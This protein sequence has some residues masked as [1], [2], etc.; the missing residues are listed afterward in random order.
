MGEGTGRCEYDGCNEFLWL[1]FVTKFEFNTAY[2]AHIIADKPGGPRGDATLSDK[3]KDDFLS[4]LML[5]CDKH[6]RL[7]DKERAKEHPVEKLREM[8]E[9]QEKRIELLT[10]I[11]DNKKSHVL[12][13]GANIGHHN[14]S[15]SWTKTVPVMLPHWIQQEIMPLN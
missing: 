10:S 1:D 2:I 4:N 8:K 13:Y 3:L 5:L 6:H 11:I 14:S 7:I 12:L 15:V 9:R